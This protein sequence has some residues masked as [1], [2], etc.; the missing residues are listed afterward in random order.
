MSF[1]RFP[2]SR[3]CQA[4]TRHPNHQHSLNGLRDL[5]LD[6]ASLLP[7]ATHPLHRGITL[8]RGLGMHLHLGMRQHLRLHLYSLRNRRLGVQQAFIS[9]RIVI[10]PVVASL[11]FNT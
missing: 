5:R 10:D 7:V 4:H 6:K 9:A 2:V 8:H 1:P 3:P 11:R